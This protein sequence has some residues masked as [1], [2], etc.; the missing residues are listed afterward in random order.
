[1]RDLRGRGTGWLIL[2]PKAEDEPRLDGPRGRD[3][4]EQVRYFRDLMGVF[5]AEGVDAV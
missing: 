2:D 4:G 5:D 1:M 3:E